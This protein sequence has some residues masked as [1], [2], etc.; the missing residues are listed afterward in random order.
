MKKL[1]LLTILAGM[2]FACKTNNDSFLNG[3]V[4]ST[5][6]SNYEASE[7]FGE[8][9]KEDLIEVRDFKFNENGNL[10][11]MIF[12]D[13]DGEETYKSTTTYKNGEAISHT[14]QRSDYLEFTSKGVRVFKDDIKTIWV[15]KKEEEGKLTSDTIIH[16]LAEDCKKKTVIEIKDDGTKSVSYYTYD[17][18]ERIVEFKWL[19]NGVDIQQW[20][21]NTYK[22]NLHTQEDRL[23]PKTGD[24][25]DVITYKYKL[26]D[27]QNWI[28]RIEYENGKATQLTERVINYR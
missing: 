5:R 21:I 19:M 23:D 6:E 14:T 15:I 22:D 10:T 25:K 1:F 11:T 20:E 17:D 28:E 12:Y 26:D 9:I 27:K 16:T 2:L 3:D 24:V 4:E 18:K 13:E 7:K 8:V